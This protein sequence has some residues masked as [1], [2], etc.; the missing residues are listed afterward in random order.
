VDLYK[1][2]NVELRN[3]IYTSFINL[4]PSCTD[5]INLVSA[6]EQIHDEFAPM[7]EPCWTMSFRELNNY[8]HV[9]F[10]KRPRQTL[11]TFNRCIMVHLRDYGIG[12]ERKLD[13]VQLVKIMKDFPSFRISFCPV[14]MGKRN[15][16]PKPL[17]DEMENAVS[18]VENMNPQNFQ[19]LVAAELEVFA[20][21]DAEKEAGMRVS[22]FLNLTIKR[23]AETVSW[24]TRL[25][26][27]RQQRMCDTWTELG[28]PA[29]Y[30]EIKIRITQK[31]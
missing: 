28:F 14:P 22:V 21:D 3:A 5:A 6:H 27:R 23:S 29:Q 15:I 17:T 18:V 19:R 7:F 10:I 24:D 25:R 30:K 9:F 16:F 20:P 12:Q 13:L 26:S 1:A 31:R 2:F 4:K 8:L 11:Q